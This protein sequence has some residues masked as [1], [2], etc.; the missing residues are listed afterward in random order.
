MNCQYIAGKPTA[1]DMCKCGEPTTGHGPYCAE[2]LAICITH[3]E[4]KSREEALAGIMFLKRRGP[5]NP[6]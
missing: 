6:I 2:H 3:R 5:T 1:N 4:R